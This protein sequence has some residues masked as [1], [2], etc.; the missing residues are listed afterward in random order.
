MQEQSTKVKSAVAHKSMETTQSSCSMVITEQYILPWKKIYVK[1]GDKVKAKQAIG[2]IV[3]DT[4][5]DNKT[6]LYFQIY[7]DRSI[8]NPGLWLAQ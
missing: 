4:S 6:E 2:E 5:E 3:T 8:I 7:K 1:Q